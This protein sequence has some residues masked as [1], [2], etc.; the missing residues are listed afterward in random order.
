MNIYSI[1]ISQIPSQMIH[2]QNIDQVVYICYNSKADQL[3]N[4]FF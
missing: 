2:I 3:V 1:N 4:Y